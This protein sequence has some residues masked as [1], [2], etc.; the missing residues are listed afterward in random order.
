MC[1]LGLGAAAILNVGGCGGGGAEEVRSVQTTARSV[2]RLAVTTSTHDTGLIEALVPLFED[3]HTCRV[4]VIAVG[5]GKALRLGERGDVDVV[6]VHAQPDEDQFMSAGHGVRREDVMYN[7]FE[8]L[9]P[10][11]DPA[12]IKG[13]EVTE[14]L[15]RI[16]V[17]KHRF[18]SRGDDSG[19][20]KRELSLWR[21]DDEDMPS[22]WD[23]YME[24]G[25]GMGAT[26][27]MAD[28][29][30]AYPLSDRG[31]YIA[32]KNK[33]DLVP[34]I[35]ASEPLINP[36]GIMTVNPGKNDRI[37]HDLANAFVDFIISPETQW[38]VG[39]F[40]LAGETLFHPLHL[41]SN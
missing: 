25:Q 38:I 17:G 41:A 18:V 32:F 11:A 30:K 36:Y 4:D 23:N 31:T 34:L 26:L 28:Q 5:S 6:L 3:Q 40:R 14:A 33:I 8:L 13:M 15:Q 24:S 10:V 2:L 35:P 21:E 12:G 39:D 29:M 16:V 7:R 1:L 27:V 9:G 20:H 37:Q 22:G 19:T